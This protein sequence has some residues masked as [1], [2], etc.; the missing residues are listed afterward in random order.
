LIDSCIS[1][2]GPRQGKGD[3]GRQG[4]PLRVGLF[5]RR[6]LRGA[7]YGSRASLR[8]DRRCLQVYNCIDIAIDKYVYV[9]ICV[10]IYIYI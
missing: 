4:A 2:G 10:Y 1:I 9:F 8:I 7:E 3:G 6:L 5:W